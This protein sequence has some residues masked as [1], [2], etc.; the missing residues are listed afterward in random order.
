[1]EALF[2]EMPKQHTEGTHRSRSPAETYAAY[3]PF[4]P[5]LGITRIA[6]VTGLDWIGMPVLNAIRQKKR[7]L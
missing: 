2:S 1:M 7:S 4:M 3:A 5:K 6:N